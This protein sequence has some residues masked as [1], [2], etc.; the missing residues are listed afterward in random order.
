MVQKV[1]ILEKGITEFFK[2]TVLEA[3]QTAAKT[4]PIRGESHKQ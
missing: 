1:K 2:T 3:A 4:V